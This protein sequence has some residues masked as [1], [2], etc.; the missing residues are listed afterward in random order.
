[1]PADHETPGQSSKISESEARPSLS[2]GASLPRADAARKAPVISLGRF[3]IVGLACLP[4]LLLALLFARFESGERALSGLSVGGVDV[5]GASGSELRH[6]LGE[7]A[8]RLAHRSVTLQVG[9]KRSAVQVQELGIFLEVEPSARRAL[10]VGRDG[11]WLTGALRYL[12]SAWTKEELPAVLRV[13]RERFEA[14]L[15]RVEPLLIEDL[16]F[17]GAIIIEGAA[18]RSAPARAGRKVSSKEALQAISEAVSSGRLEAPIVLTARAETPLVVAGSLERALED[19]KRVLGQRVVLES[20]P[21]RLELTPEELGSLL[22]GRVSDGVASV[23]VDVGRF[24]SWL[25][26][27]RASLEGPAREATFE[28][29]PQDEVRVVPGEPGAKLVPEA[30]SAALLAAARTEARRGELPL[31]REPLPVRSTER[32][33]ALGI[34][35][36]V[37]A[38]TTR[39][40]CCQPRVDNIHRIATLLDGLVVEPGQ[41]VSVNAVVG[42]RTLKNGFVLA[43]SI[44]DGE[45][46]DTFGGG[47]SQFAT[48]LFNA[49]FRS[50]YEILERKP[51]TYW[52]P[53]YPMG[54]EATLSWPHPDILFK[55][56]T[57][58]GLLVKTSFTDKSVT[59]KLYGDVGGRRVM[60]R[61]SE[62]RD[63]VNPVVEL[64]PNREVLPD[65]EKVKEGGS[66][67]WSVLVERTVTFADGTKREDK[68]KVTYKPR[69]RRVEV[70][71]CRIP[72]GDPGATGEPC[73]EPP[74]EEEPGAEP[75]QPD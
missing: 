19:A 59:V 8:A 46:V 2:T 64:L 10:G 54:I 16:P 51:H 11:G 53:R 74:P 18:A 21:R 71:P 58:A 65:E 73:P 48:T 3:L 61:V 68:R 17:P 43:P 14:G 27:R 41:Q 67:G 7:R 47:V 72:K 22:V 75:P 28:V 52:F 32:A 60:T 33:E 34:R 24:E 44:E 26:P 39:H 25:A 70:H 38:F 6:V 57:E 5:S 55:N 66:I 20:G 63:I 4:L 45:M 29:S 13:D 50:G 40:P 62:R 69:A 35:R 30:V 37:G 9:A 56:D 42:P 31:L 1:M 23:G 49:L 36:L 15:A 12:R